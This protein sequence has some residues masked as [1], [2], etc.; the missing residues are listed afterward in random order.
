VQAA[1]AALAFA[2]RHPQF[3]G[4]WDA[5]SG[6]LVLLAAED[7]LALCRLLDRAVRDGSPAVPFREPDLGGA[8]TAVA[9]LGAPQAALAR[10]PLALEGGETTCLS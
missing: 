9:L 7:E 8:L 10:L 6:T 3:T 4:E 5:A 1:H 2:I